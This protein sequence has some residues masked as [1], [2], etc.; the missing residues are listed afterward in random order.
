M[1]AS[2]QNVCVT[3]LYTHLKFHVCRF[4]Y[5]LM[6]THLINSTDTTL[7]TVVHSVVDEANQQYV[8]YNARAIIPCFIS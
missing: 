2:F 8:Y 4:K 5:E 3:I 1:Y 6:L 7:H